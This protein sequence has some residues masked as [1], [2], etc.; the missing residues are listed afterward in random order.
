MKK[1]KRTKFLISKAGERWINEYLL[2]IADQTKW[3]GKKRNLC[4]NEAVM[5]STDS[6]TNDMKLGRLIEVYPD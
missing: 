4:I 5:L 6:M 1:D 3:F 2:N